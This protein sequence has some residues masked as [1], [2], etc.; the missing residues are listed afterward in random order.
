MALAASFI[1][2][3]FCIVSCVHLFMENHWTKVN[4]SLV[5]S[6]ISTYHQS[7]ALKITYKYKVGDK[8]YGATETR[9]LDSLRAEMK[10]DEKANFSDLDVVQKAKS[11]LENRKN[12]S[13]YYNA[14]SPIESRL[15]DENKVLLILYALLGAVCTC[16]FFWS[17]WVL[18]RSSGAESSRAFS[19]FHTKQEKDLAA[20]SI[21]NRNYAIIDSLREKGLAEDIATCTSA[22]NLIPSDDTTG[23]TIQDGET[24]NIKQREKDVL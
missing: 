23:E 4:A 22:P 16:G 7:P 15:V 13:V 11:K 12:F 10:S 8:L 14:S 17:V 9:Q 21:R 24:I 5:K 20:E 19:D 3:V 6:E 2:G 18:T 1:V